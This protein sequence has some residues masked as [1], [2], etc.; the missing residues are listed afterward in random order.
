[1]GL[2]LRSFD[3]LRKFGTKSIGEIRKFGT[4]HGAEINKAADF[5]QKNALPTIEKVGRGV[6][7]G[8]KVAAPIISEINPTAGRIVG[9]VGRGAGMA[10][11][12]AGASNRA[13]TKGR[14]AVRQGDKIVSDVEAGR[15]ASAYG[16]G[17][18]LQRTLRR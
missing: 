13:I 6:A 1:M 11:K 15:L 14:E 2:S 4:K 9:L 5:L 18:A 17:Q 16:R 10:A 7:E 8:A 3:S 12:A